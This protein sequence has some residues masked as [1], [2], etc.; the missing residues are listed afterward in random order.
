MLLDLKFREVWY[1][2][3]P[4]QS[5]LSLL[6]VRAILKKKIVLKKALIRQIKEDVHNS[7]TEHVEEMSDGTLIK[8]K[9][10]KMF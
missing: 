6:T 9:V 1:C 8:I 7:E 3:E 10:L 5:T 4:Q 2:G